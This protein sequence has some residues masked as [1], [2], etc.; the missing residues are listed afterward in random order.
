MSLGA[1]PMSL[2]VFPIGSRLLV[3]TLGMHGR[4][5]ATWV[6]MNSMGT[7]V[8]IMG[9]HVIWEYALTDSKLG[10]VYTL[11]GN[12]WDDFPHLGRLS[13][14]AKTSDAW[15][16]FQYMGSLPIYGKSCHIIR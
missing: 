1:L 11:T 7:L 13:I 10:S 12:T 15:E 14:C 16:D 4:P 8:N 6:P 2:R 5:W 3:K 9:T